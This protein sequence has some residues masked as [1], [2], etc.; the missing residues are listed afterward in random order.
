MVKKTVTKEQPKP[1]VIKAKKLNLRSVY[2][3]D[4]KYT[5]P[6]PQ[7]DT[8]RALAMPDSEFEHFMRKSFYYYNYHYNQKDT[9]K[10][11]DEYLALNNYDAKKVKIFEKVSDSQIPMT[12]CSIILAHR[13]GM[14]IKPKIKTFIDSTFDR[15]TSDL[16]VKK[17]TADND[18][19][20]TAVKVVTIQDR[21]AEKTAEH[22]GELEGIYDM[23]I[24]KKEPPMKM[25]QFLTANNV[26]QSQIN[27]FIELIQ[28][29]QNELVLAQ[30]GKDSQLVEAYK[31]FKASD[32]KRHLTFFKQCLD[33][34]EQYKSVKKATKKARIKKPTSKDKLVAKLQYLKE[35]KGLKLVSINPIDIIG[36]KVLWIFNT[37]TRKLGKY[38]SEDNAELAVKGTTI[39]NFDTQ[40]SVCKTI[41]KPEEKLKEFMK[42]TKVQLRKF[43]SDIKATETKLNG[44]INKDIVLLKVE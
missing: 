16:A 3:A 9:R 5:G 4:E 36:A 38:M 20:K 19:K 10:F 24:M 15:L 11:V 2:A 39:L 7:W 17:I 34:L 33:D 44:R 43:L 12:L 27:K 1:V 22:L 18:N 8:E 30:Q 41:R 13:V 40:K 6:E 37:T 35:D 25:Y 42:S 31:H 14:P 32:F 21:L 29:R 28:Y 23:I 26:P